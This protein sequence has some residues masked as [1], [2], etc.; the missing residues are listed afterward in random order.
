MVGLGGREHVRRV[1]HPF[2]ATSTSDT[3][4]ARAEDF[5]STSFRRVRPIRRGRLKRTVASSG[6]AE[7]GA[8]LPRWADV[9]VAWRDLLMCDDSGCTF[10]SFPQTVSGIVG[11]GGLKRVERQAE[12]EQRHRLLKGETLNHG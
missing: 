10:D 12:D 1:V 8:M 2:T 6:E 7:V 4:A 3:D 9:L 11:S 5:G